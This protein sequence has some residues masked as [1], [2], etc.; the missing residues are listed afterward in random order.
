MNTALVAQNEKS[1]TEHFKAKYPSEVKVYALASLE[2]LEAAWTTATRNGYV[3]PKEIK[4]SIKKSDRNALYFNRK[5]LR[6]IVWEYEQISEM[7]PPD[8]SKK[9]NIY[10]LCHEIGHLCMYNTTHNRNSWM[11]YDYREAWADY[12]GNM[13][14][15][16]LYDEFGIDIWPE[17]HDYRKYAGIEY[18]IARIEKNSPKLQSFNNA[19]LFWYELGAELGFSNIQK[20]FSAINEEKVDNPG[21]LDKFANVLERYLEKP[22]FQEW[23]D[24]YSGALI[25]SKE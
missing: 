24:Q 21:A 14:V 4:L 9:N 11:S 23:F 1:E 19:S 8:Q 13:I 3:L 20:L 18:L 16:S 5:S 17:P 25:I 22:N 7:L 10:G 6:E 15:D 12:F 2:V